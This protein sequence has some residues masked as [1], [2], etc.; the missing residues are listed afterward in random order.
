MV[1]WAARGL[2]GVL[3]NVAHKIVSSKRELCASVCCWCWI[4]MDMPGLAFMD[5]FQRIPKLKCRLIQPVDC[6]IEML[7]PQNGLRNRCFDRGHHR[8][9]PCAT[10][11]LEVI[12]LWDR[13]V[14]MLRPWIWTGSALGWKTEGWFA[15]WS[16]QPEVLFE[17]NS[18]GNEIW[19]K[20][21][22]QRNQKNLEIVVDQY[23][24]LLGKAVP[25]AWGV[26]HGMAAWIIC[27]AEAKISCRRWPRSSDG[28]G[29][30]RLS[31]W[32]YTDNSR[33]VVYVQIFNTLQ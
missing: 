25:R 23:T 28:P 7:C 5:T 21:Q 8:A 9:R 16:S 13:Q 26:Q 22:N 2:W 30:M 32:V 33:H 19:L 3:R 20:T 4:C 10:R 29:D 17:R 15:S 24:L 11:R 18:G 12:L 1:L 14:R 31:W 6:L 27:F